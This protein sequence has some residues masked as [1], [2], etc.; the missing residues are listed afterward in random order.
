MGK[1]RMPIQ[2]SPR[3]ASSAGST[4]PISNPSPSS[5]TNGTK[6]W[7]AAVGNESMVLGWFRDAGSEPPDWKLLP[8]IQGQIVTITV[9]G[10]LPRTGRWIS[11]IPRPGMHLSGS[12]MLTR[13]GNR[14]TV[15]L[16]DFTD[17]I[18]FKLFANT[19]GA[20]LPPPT[21]EPEPTAIA[22]TNTD[23]V[24]GEWVG[25]VFQVNGEWAAVLHV[26]IEFWL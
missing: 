6:I 26:D 20:I 13:Q 11:T 10:H 2:N 3:F 17:D 22:P 7:G 23:P 12:A 19:S 8:S 15:A 25:S 18:A 16:P 1:Y 5:T 9:P 4:S 21:P 24:A 14:V